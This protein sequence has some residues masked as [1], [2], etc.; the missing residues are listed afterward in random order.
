MPPDWGPVMRLGVPTAE[1]N[2]ALICAA[3]SSV[4]GF[5][6]L[7][8]VDPAGELVATDA[9]ELPDDGDVVLVDELPPQADSIRAP[10]P[11]TPKM[12]RPLVPIAHPQSWLPIDLAVKTC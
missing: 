10:E 2:A 9:G 8:D 7:A 1:P 5:G 6:W 11:A 4:Q 12:R 3:V